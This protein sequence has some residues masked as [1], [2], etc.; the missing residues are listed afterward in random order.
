MF[1]KT[2]FIALYAFVFLA[3][4]HL[5]SGMPTISAGE[6]FIEWSKRNP[7]ACYGDCAGRGEPY[8]GRGGEGRATG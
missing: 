7:A 1:K 3:T 5:A 4:L 6:H 8:T 2:L